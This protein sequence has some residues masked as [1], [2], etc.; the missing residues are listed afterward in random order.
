VTAGLDAAVAAG[1]FFASLALTPAAAMIARRVGLVDHPGPLKPHAKPTP[2][3]G[4]L[5]VAAGTAVGAAV[6][7]PWLLVPLAMALMLGTADDLRP[8]P[9]IVRLGAELGT[10]AV[11]AAVIPTRFGGAGGFVL[12]MVAAVALMNGFNLVDGLDALCGTVTVTASVGFAVLLGGDAR[13]FAL[14]LAAATAAFVVFNRPPARVYLGDGGA[15]LIGTA[16]AAL[17]AEAWGPHRSLA[18]G[19][20]ALALVVVPAAELALAVLRRARNRTSLLLG[21]RDH[22]YDQLVRRG[23]STVRVDA[24]YGLV[25]LALLGIAVGA[26]ALPSPWAALLV[27]GAVAV[28]G[29]LVVEAGFLSPGSTGL[30]EGVHP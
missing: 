25:G 20:G 24:A 10:G 22:P 18:T 14:A 1:A 9:P 6:F 29:A 16:V 12:V 8:L 5:G 4:G 30:T 13:A 2:Y 11:L 23:W 7:R 27:A 15:Y 28:L 3:L 21:D 26:A 17:L 19:I